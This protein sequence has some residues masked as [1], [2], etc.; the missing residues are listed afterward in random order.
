MARGDDSDVYIMKES[1]TFFVVS[2]EIDSNV[3]VK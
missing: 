3:N 2:P 1:D